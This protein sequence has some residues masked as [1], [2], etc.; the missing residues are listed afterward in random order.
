M[1]R[2]IFILFLLTISAF[3]FLS[4]STQS[5]DE[6]V[7]YTSVD[8]VFAE[9]ILKDLQQE[10][11]ITVKAVFDTEETKSTGVLNRLI[12][13]AANPQCDVFWS[14]D[15]VRA[16]VLKQKGI[17][18]PYQSKV[19]EGIPA[20]FIDHDKHWTGFSSRARV[21]IYNKNLVPSDKIP[22]SL[23]DLTKEEYKGKV[24]I[25]N[26]LFGTTSFHIAAIFSALGDEKAK[27]WLSDLK[28]NNV[29]IATSNGD[30]KK[31]VSNGEIWCGLT[32]TDDANEAIKEGAPV[33]IVFLG[34]SD[35]GALIIPNTVSLI[36]NSPNGV[37]AK[38]AID[39][40]ISKETQLKLAKSCAQMPLSKGVE[41]PQ[42]VFSLDKV[43]AMQ[44]NYDQTSKKLEE[45][46]NY[47]KEW[48]EN[49]S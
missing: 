48:V 43:K 10:T 40:L 35:I 4:C 42:G 46:Q 37:N 32:D 28:A 45:I 20:Y 33:G 36:K 41:V 18:E 44:V 13:E 9:P 17:S 25:A 1:S 30:V 23:L 26:P 21:L 15:P 19:A 8:Q 31:R 22:S 5:S 39:Y 12:A 34:Q 2:C 24:A 11:G 49:N 29:I 7:I 14:G 38:K 47:L 6:V 16:N 27:K 3:L